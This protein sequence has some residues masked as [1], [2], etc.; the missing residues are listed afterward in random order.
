MQWAIR[1]TLNN[2]RFDDIENNYLITFDAAESVSTC[3]GTSKLI[4]VSA[5]LL[6]L[7][8]RAV[9]FEDSFSSEK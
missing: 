7:L 1:V 2:Y 8:D 5:L 3:A 4:A 9:P 6:P